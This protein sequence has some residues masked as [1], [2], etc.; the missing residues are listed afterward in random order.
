MKEKINIVWFKRD[1]RLNDHAPLKEAELDELPTLLLYVFEP[2]LTGSRHYDDRHWRFVYESLMHM[3]KELQASS[4]RMHILHGEVY[5]VFEAVSQQ[6]EIE[7]IFSHEETG[8]DL[9]FQR[10]LA[11]ADWCK[12]K[13]IQWFEYPTNAVHRGLR[14][15]DGWKSKWKN[16]IES[17]PLTNELSHIVMPDGDFEFDGLEIHDNWKKKDSNFQPGGR[18][19]ALS[20]LQSFLEERG[21]RYSKSISRPSES[22]DG[23]SRISPYLTWGN[24]S[25]REVHKA[26]RSVYP[27]STFKRPLRSWESRLNWHCHFIQKF[28]SEPEIEF[29]NFNAG[30]DDI[31]TEEDDHYIQAWKAGNTGYPLVDAC[32]RAV[33]ATGYL[34]FRMRAML[35]SFLTHHLWQDWRSGAQFLGR[36]FLDFE[37]GIHYPQFQM[38]AGSIGINTIRIYNPVKQS[39]DHDEKGEFIKEWVPEL[40]GLPETLIHEPW[41][42]SDMEQEM[43]DCRIGIDYPEPIV[44]IKKTYHRASKA[45]W[46]KKADPK[47]KEENERIK[48]I[49]VKSRRSYQS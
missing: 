27:D 32:M 37:P 47:V 24:L 12:G 36:Q 13:S 33:C 5:E 16:R 14:N 29:R 40:R 7:C 22:R 4:L 43:Y 21:G 44:D 25:L 48:A 34:N 45:L 9:T 3:Q 11:F 15:R 18:E 20:T 8:I 38:Q 2:M 30:Y 42:M 26:F 35:V 41:K 19:E 6:F 46:A 31:R 10:D 39:Y 23:C 28:E 17:E 1:L 49:H